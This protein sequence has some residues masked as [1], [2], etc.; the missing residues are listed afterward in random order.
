MCILGRCCRGIGLCS[1]VVALCFR[2]LVGV[3]GVVGVGSCCRGG[4]CRIQRRR[5]LVRMLVGVIVVGVVVHGREGGRSGVGGIAVQLR[6][7][8]R[9]QAQAGQGHQKG[10]R[11]AHIR[12]A[13]AR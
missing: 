8:R 1:V 13:A 7:R 12:G 9:Q 10:P 3:V 2:V 11:D 5:R 4:G 6:R